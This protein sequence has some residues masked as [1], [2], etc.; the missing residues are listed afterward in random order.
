MRRRHVLV[1]DRLEVEHVERLA[2]AADQ[3]VER[4][5]SPDHRI[6]QAP[7]LLREGLGAAEQRAGG[8]E[9]TAAGGGWSACLGPSDELPQEGVAGV[10]L[11]TSPRTRWAGGPA[12]CRRGRRSRSGCRGRGRCRPR[13]RR[14]RHRCGCRR[15]IAARA[16]RLPRSPAACRP[17]TNERRFSVMLASG[18]LA[19]I[20]GSS[21][22]ATYFSARRCTSQGSSPGRVR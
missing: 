4:A 10:H 16:W 9:L 1:R 11:R 19:F 7:Q 3:L 2:R 21:S 18:C 22:S 5:R 15:S 20:L 13:C 8:E 12:R 17:G 14:A 6:G